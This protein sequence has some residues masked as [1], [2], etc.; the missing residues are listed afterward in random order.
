MFFVCYLSIGQNVLKSIND[1][2]NQQK[3]IQKEI[4]QK[5]IDQQNKI[6]KELHQKLKDT[7]NFSKINVQVKKTEDTAK[8]QMSIADKKYEAD[9][10]IGNPIKLGNI[11]VAQEEIPYAMNF[12]Q[13]QKLIP[14]ILGKGWRLPNND[15][16]QLMVKNRD[17]VG[18]TRH[19]GIYLTSVFFHGF[20]Y[21]VYDLTSGNPHRL[22]SGWVRAVKDL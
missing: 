10:I 14:E 22:T 6:Q 15:D 17:K 2:I 9:R 16:I 8:L 20:G 21:M 7:A 12:D 18:E 4:F 5:G 1:Q 11:L 13:A 19:S 3:K